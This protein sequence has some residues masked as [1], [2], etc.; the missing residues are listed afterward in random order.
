MSSSRRAS[1]SPPSG[2][3]GTQ[4]PH[5]VTLRTP[6]APESF[7]DPLHPA[8]RWRRTRGPAVAQIVPLISL[9]E[10]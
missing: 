5:L 7:E 6:G 1:G 3:S 10:S 4:D 2:D 8:D 9:D